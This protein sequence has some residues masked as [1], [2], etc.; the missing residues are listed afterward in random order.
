MF[1]Y[2]RRIIYY[3]LVLMSSFLI[4][5]FLLYRQVEENFDVRAVLDFDYLANIAIDLSVLNHDQLITKAI[6][7]E[8]LGL[9]NLNHFAI[10]D[11]DTL[12]MRFFVY[13]GLAGNL[14]RSEIVSVTKYDW[15][16]AFYVMLN[17]NAMSTIYLNTND[18]KLIGFTEAQNQ[19]PARIETLDKDYKRH[20]FWT[21]F[22]C[23]KV[24]F[25]LCN[26]Q[27]YV[28]SIYSD[29][30]SHDDSFTLSVPFKYSDERFG[31]VN[32]DIRIKDLFFQLFNPEVYKPDIIRV[33]S[34][35]YRHTC[36]FGVV[37]FAKEI[38]I[39][40]QTFTLEW[41]FTD[42][43]SFIFERIT[44]FKYI[45]SFCIMLA[46]AYLLER[47]LMF[48]LRAAAKDN[49]TKLHKRPSKSVA[50]RLNY[51]YLLILDIDNF[52][53]VNDTYGH[54]IGDLVLIALSRQLESHKRK[55]DF[56]Y[57]WGGEE[58]VLLF[59][60]VLHPDDMVSIVK[61]L[62]SK[63]VIIDGYSFQVTFSGGLVK[64]SGNLNRDVERA[65]ELL[66]KVKHAGKDNILCL[67]DDAHPF[68]ARNYIT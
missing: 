29:P 5:S 35:Y 39:Y 19:V 51:D 25:A 64:A 15:L 28:S 27:P 47:V 3:S 10:V 53:S 37:C 55:K 24:G 60:E 66:Y 6:D 46:L 30:V 41:F 20:P 7:A 33:R 17:N 56:L 42:F 4:A 63:P 23:E 11:A 14:L 36:G 44:S 1:K 43:F 68:F 21:H 8:R 22:F 12:S 58:F 65:D 52:K 59:N 49:L 40:N 26:R 45:V 16:A 54:H 13:D 62:L 48:F 2:K 38:S 32:V 31:L 50:A 34:D 18:H 67:F 57:R 61:R 9:R